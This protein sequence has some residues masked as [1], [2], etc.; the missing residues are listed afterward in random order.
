MSGAKTRFGFAGDGSEPP[1]SDE[2][3]AAQTVIG[4]D[5]HLQ[6]P[7][8]A[9]P[10]VRPAPPSSVPP[11]W[12]MPPQNP[13]VPMPLSRSAVPVYLPEE[14]TAE[15]PSRRRARSG[16][17]RLARFL[18]RWTKSGRFVSGSRSSLD[19]GT[20]E[21]PSAPLAQNV[22][23]VI[24]VALVTFLL[25]LFVVKLRQQAAS[26]SQPGRAMV[27]AAPSGPA[28]PLPAA[29]APVPLGAIPPNTLPPLAPTAVPAASPVK[30]APASAASSTVARGLTPPA[31]ARTAGLKPPRPAQRS[32]VAERAVPPE[33]L[34]SELLPMSNAAR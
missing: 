15:L 12:V 17:S 25:T 10:P 21:G 26:P 7:P 31:T 5:I 11:T 32:V 8:P 20:R 23:L 33:H 29:R 19:G 34:K 24:V 2:A 6:M 3:R 9:A 30:A 4:H 13:D 16:Q 28:P 14:A 1:D 27:I 22:I 18:G